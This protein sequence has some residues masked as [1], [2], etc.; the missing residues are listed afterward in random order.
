MYKVKTEL[1]PPMGCQ[2]DNSFKGVT[3]PPGSSNFYAKHLMEASRLFKGWGINDPYLLERER[4]ERYMGT[5]TMETMGNYYVWNPV[6][7]A[8]TLHYS[9]YYM[10]RFSS[11]TRGGFMCVWLP[12]TDSFTYVHRL[13]FSRLIYAFRC[14]VDTFVGLMPRIH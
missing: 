2:L 12:L 3:S 9:P 14:V 1:G 4:I 6:I 10:G 13:G 5:S 8:L 11:T 7:V